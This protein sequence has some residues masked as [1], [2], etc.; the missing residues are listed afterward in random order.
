MFTADL[1]T[2]VEG[3]YAAWDAAFN[4]GDTKNI[5]AAYLPNDGDG[6]PTSSKSV[7]LIIAP[8]RT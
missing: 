6:R 1:N 8:L 5:A 7:A 2:D 4:R 3:A